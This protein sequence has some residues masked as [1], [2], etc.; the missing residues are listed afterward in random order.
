MPVYSH[1][2]HRTGES[3]FDLTATLSIRNT[4]PTAVLRIRDVDYFDSEGTLLR[5]FLD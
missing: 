3:E 5:S 2:F 4:S 1:I